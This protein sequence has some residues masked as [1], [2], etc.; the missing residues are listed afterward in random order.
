MSYKLETL[1]KLL[2]NTFVISVLK[3]NDKGKFSGENLN[4]WLKLQRRKVF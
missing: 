4:F 1:V 3:A 2:E